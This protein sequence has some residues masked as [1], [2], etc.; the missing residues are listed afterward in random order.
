MP[1]TIPK[2]GMGQRRDKRNP[3]NLT[4]YPRATSMPFRHEEIQHECKTLSCPVFLG[5]SRKL[6]ELSLTISSQGM[7]DWSRTDFTW[8][9]NC[10][11]KRGS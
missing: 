5:A 3:G 7:H 11:D 10:K 8:Q 9:R 6:P 4:Y 2:A 1:N